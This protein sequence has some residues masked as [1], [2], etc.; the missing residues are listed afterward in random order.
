MDGLPHRV[1]T[2]TKWPWSNEGQAKAKG[3]KIVEQRNY[4]EDH[5]ATLIFVALLGLRRIPWRR[6]SC[7]TW[8]NNDIHL[9]LFFDMMN[10]LACRLKQSP[11][12]ISSQQAAF[13][14]CRFFV[15]S[16]SSCRLAP[17]QFGVQTQSAFFWWHGN[18]HPYFISASDAQWM[19]YKSRPTKTIKCL[20][21]FVVI[22]KR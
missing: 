18:N 17:L 15:H 14:Y 12:A 11:F 13:F 10:A 6:K 16:R 5:N 8:E 4:Q 19:K 1:W 22:W 7:P 3:R 2:G 9:L 21:F 20:C